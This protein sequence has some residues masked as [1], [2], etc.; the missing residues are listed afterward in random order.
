M[1]VIVDTK[2]T[3]FAK[4][5]FG[6]ISRLP[7]IHDVQAKKKASNINREVV[8]IVYENDSGV[9]NNATANNDHIQVQLEL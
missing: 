9:T 6:S 1:F 2:I 5:V 8:V 7:I 3:S 4:T